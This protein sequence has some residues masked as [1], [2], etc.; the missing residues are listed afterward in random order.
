MAQPTQPE[1]LTASELLALREGLA[2][3]TLVSGLR[4][5]FGFDNR[6]HFESMKNEALSTEP[7]LNRIIQ[8][9]AQGRAAME[10]EVTIRERMNVLTP[11]QR[12]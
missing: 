12:G 9:A 11:K 5:I 3:A 6:M 10:F 4:K 2:N 8:F 7:N 1:M